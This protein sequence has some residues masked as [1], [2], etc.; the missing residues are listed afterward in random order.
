MKKSLLYALILSS[1]VAGNTQVAQAIT[2]ADIV[3]CL[4]AYTAKF[5]N[6]IGFW[7][8]EQAAPK[9]VLSVTSVVQQ[10]ITVQD[11]PPVIAVEQKPIKHAEP[12]PVKQI[13]ECDPLGRLSIFL[14]HFNQKCVWFKRQD[15]SLTIGTVNALKSFRSGCGSILPIVHLPVNKQGWP[16]EIPTNKKRWFAVLGKEDC[17]SARNTYDDFGGATDPG[18]TGEDTAIREFFEEAGNSKIVLDLDLKDIKNHIDPKN[19]NIEQIVAQENLG[20]GTN[21]ITYIARFPADIVH[22]FKDRFINARNATADHHYQEKDAIALFPFDEL[23][24]AITACPDQDPSI[25]MPALIIA[26]TDHCDINAIKR[27]KVRPF[28][29]IKLRDYFISLS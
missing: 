6:L 10:S 16:T 22:K 11:K 17:G 26:S 19:G 20:F 5:I 4:R 9:P 14:N 24:Q 15:G 2:M 7:K 21:A 29:V 23:Q 25:T 1:L 8:P 18:E 27:V 28:L 13:T 3:S 12:L